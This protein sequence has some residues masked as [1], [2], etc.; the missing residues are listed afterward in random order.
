MLCATEGGA[1]PHALVVAIHCSPSH[2]RSFTSSFVLVAAIVLAAI[3][4]VVAAVIVVGR[5][6]RSL[7]LLCSR[8]WSSSSRLPLCGGGGGGHGC[9]HVVVV[10]VV[11]N[12]VVIVV[13][14]F[15]WSSSSLW[16]WWSLWSS[17]PLLPRGGQ[18]YRSCGCSTVA[19]VIAG[20]VL[21]F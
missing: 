7:W 17:S 20:D 5:C 15:W 6:G 8:P 21:I 18:G 16:W 1:T 12:V 4:A 14:S 13:S 2:H 10:V 19:A 3:A 11:V 9:S